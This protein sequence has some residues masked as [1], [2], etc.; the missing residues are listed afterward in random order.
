[1]FLTHTTHSS[2]DY[3]LNLDV[4]T[5]NALLDAATRFDAARWTQHAWLARVAYHADQKGFQK[6]VKEAWGHA[7]PDP[8][9]E[10][11]NDISKLIRDFGGGF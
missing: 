9:N 6:T 3:L 2:F 8:A 1:M 11:K 4:L 10:K 5:F 7:T